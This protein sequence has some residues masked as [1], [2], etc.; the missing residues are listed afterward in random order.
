MAPG[1]QVP[2][3]EEMT[4]LVALAG[5]TALLATTAA[6]ASGG[7]SSISALRHK[8]GQY[9][10]Q[11]SEPAP[12]LLLVARKSVSFVAV[13]GKA[14]C[15]DVETGVT[16]SLRLKQQVEASYFHQGRAWAL[17]RKGR[18]DGTV[19][20]REQVRGQNQ[21]ELRVSGKVKGSR[22][23]GSAGYKL[24]LKRE[25]CNFGRRHFTAKWTGKDEYGR[26]PSTGP[27]PRR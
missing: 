20:N 13:N 4:R 19:K 6:T 23:S 5:L 22:V 16:R 15:T 21:L 12:V 8:T 10:G 11:T 18:F 7:G 3:G 26:G 25:S 14:D 27:G 9:V 24:Q 2:Y 1:G 17:D